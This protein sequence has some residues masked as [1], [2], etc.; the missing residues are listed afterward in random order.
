MRM[1]N[2]KD[3]SLSYIR[4][5]VYGDS[6]IGKTTSL[7]TLPQDRTLIAAAER[8]LIPLR[9]CDFGV[10]VIE[11]WDDTRELAVACR[12][13]PI[14]VGGKQVSVL[15]IDSL[16]EIGEL[17][18]KHIVEVDRRKLISDRTKGKTEVPQ[19]VYD[20]QMTQE[21]WGLYT[22]RMRNLLSAFCHLPCHIIFTALSS[23]TE[24][25]TDGKVY[26]G[27]ALNGKLAR[28]CCGQFDLVLHMESVTQP[29]NS[30]ER[31]W[32]TFNDGR[33]LAKDASGKLD[34]FEAANWTSAFKKILNGKEAK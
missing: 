13:D 6:G 27:P 24:D 19:G 17:C 15:A 14:T 22:T 32:R 9:G 18:K 26:R 1:T 28:E 23:L 34:Q 11:S 21:D 20:D 3:K 33:V 16:T 31:V 8:G 4:A 25:K 30:N 29:D 5:L 12:A 10:A 7:R 2:S